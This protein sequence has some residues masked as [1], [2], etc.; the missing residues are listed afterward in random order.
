[1]CVVFYS[2]YFLKPVHNQNILLLPQFIPNNDVEQ[3]D[4]W[5]ILRYTADTGGIPNF[6]RLKTLMKCVSSQKK[7]LADYFA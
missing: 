3:S 7:M 1:M 4:H 6:A 2:L 5:R